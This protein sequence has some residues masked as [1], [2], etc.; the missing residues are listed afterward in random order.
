MQTIK[1]IDPLSVA[2]ISSLMAAI[3]G[4]ISGLYLAVT[5][6][7]ALLFGSSLS[8][9]GIIILPVLYGISIYIVSYISVLI[10]NALAN[11][12]GGIK[13]DLGKK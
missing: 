11:K 6:I 1:S 3:F 10:Y 13:I 8:Y 9:L 12:V 7:G 5:G 4:L 2:K